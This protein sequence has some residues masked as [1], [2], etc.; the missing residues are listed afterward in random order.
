MLNF[1]YQNGTRILFGKGQIGQIGK[2]VAGARVLLMAG[3]GSIK[4]NGVYEQVKAALGDR[5]V[6][7]FF[8]VEPN[9][10]YATL[11]RAVALAKAE[12]VDFL[13]A[14]GGGSVIDG[15]KFVAAAAGVEG[16]PWDILEKG[17]PVT[18]AL[19][20]GVVLTLPAA[21][22]ESNES[23]VISRS[24]LGQ[25]LFFGSP[26]V[27]PKFA[28]LD[29]EV[30]YTLP[31]R[32]TANGIVDTFV[33][34]MEQYLT[35]PVGGVLQDRWAE[36]ILLTLVEQG[37]LALT[38]P[39]DYSIRATLMWASTLAL[40]GVIAQGVPQDWTTHMIGHEL[41]ALYGIDHARTLAIVLP[42]LMAARREQKREKLLQYGARV[43]GVTEGTESARIGRTIAMTRE[44]FESVGIPT[45]LS[46]YG[47]DATAI[48]KVIANLQ[49]NGRLALGERGD[50]TP[51]IAGKL[52]E[53]SL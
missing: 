30:T 25:K 3:G 4:K 47:I 21:G 20:I 38:S 15:T 17:K 19:P 51:E 2:H 40:N 5:T 48:P 18:C 52:L 26:L 41:T 50:I 10:E 42:A 14:A 36:G 11:M 27:L 34:V 12:K 24:E 46:A 33:H 32:Q 35:Y 53:L 28:A 7:E 23:A 45:R 13:V 16:E 8:G 49:R 9:P 22:S 31:E 1:E 29:P 37:P 43:F 39:N 6:F 44:F